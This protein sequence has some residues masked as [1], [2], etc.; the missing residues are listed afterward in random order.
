[1]AFNGLAHLVRAAVARRDHRAA[2]TEHVEQ[3]VDPADVIEQQEYQRAIA[4]A[5]RLELGDKLVE[6]EDRRLAFAGRS[7][8]EQNQ[9]GGAAH[10]DL[11]QQGM[12]RDAREP[13][14]AGCIVPAELDREPHLR[15]LH[16]LLPLARRRRRQGDD[17][18]AVDEPGEQQGAQSRGVIAAYRERA[19]WLDSLP[20]EVL[21]PRLHGLARAGRMTS[22][23][24]SPD[25]GRSIA[26]ALQAFEEPVL[27]IG[28]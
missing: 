9:A 12:I 18:V 23:A 7:R 6:I 22:S 28:Y 15:G 25:Q 20:G 11:A 26:P 27:L 21:E 2:V 10:A 24:R 8:A 17:D 16:Q 3:R 19:S 1:M 5:R 4:R 13:P 14:Q